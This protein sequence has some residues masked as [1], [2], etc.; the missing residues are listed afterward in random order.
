MF[1]SDFVTKIRRQSLS[2]HVSVE[3]LPN[4]FLENLV[5]EVDNE[6]IRGIVLGG[7]QARGDATP[8][9]DVDLECFVPDTFRPLRKRFMY[10][11]GL[12]ISIVLKTLE[13][14]KQ[15]LTNPYQALWAVPSFRQARVLLDKDGSMT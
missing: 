1:N 12:L 4:T 5:A 7:S 13:D 10:R 9:S 8:Y 2:P 6:D 14:I 15:Q 3:S 11:E